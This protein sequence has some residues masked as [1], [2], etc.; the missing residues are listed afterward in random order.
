MAFNSAPTRNKIPIKEK[1]ISPQESIGPKERAVQDLVNYNTTYAP[2]VK[3][4]ERALKDHPNHHTEASGGNG[5]LPPTNSKNIGSFSEEPND[6]NINILN[7]NSTGVKQIIPSGTVNYG[8]VNQTIIINNGNNSS[9]N[10]SVGGKIVTE[11]SRN[12]NIKIGNVNQE[13]IND[14]SRRISMSDFNQNIPK[15]EVPNVNIENPRVINTESISNT[16]LKENRIDI[17]AL[18]ILSDAYQDPE[19]MKNE[20]NEAFEA[21][22]EEIQLEFID[23]LEKALSSNKFVSLDAKLMEMQSKISKIKSEKDR[24]IS[25]LDEVSEYKKNSNIDS[26]EYTR[27]TKE[28]IGEYRENLSQFDRTAKED[29]QLENDKLPLREHEEASFFTK[30]KTGFSRI[31][32]TLKSILNYPNRPFK[33]EKMLVNGKLKWDD[34]TKDKISNRVNARYFSAREKLGYKNANNPLRNSRSSERYDQYDDLDISGNRLD[35]QDQRKNESIE[36]GDV[37]D[38]K[39]AEAYNSQQKLNYS[40]KTKF[41]TSQEGEVVVNQ[42]ENVNYSEETPI[43][44]DGDFSELTTKYA[45]YTEELKELKEQKEPLQEQLDKQQED[46][47]IDG[48]ENFKKMKE[49]SNAIKLM[50]KHSE[51][52]RVKLLESIEKFNADL[53]NFSQDRIDEFEDVNSLSDVNR[54]KKAFNSGRYTIPEFSGLIE[55]MPPA[56][57]SSEI[58]PKEKEILDAVA[59]I[60]KNRT[61]VTNLFFSINKSITA[62]EN[63]YSSE[64][65]IDS[66]K[67]Y[68]NKEGEILKRGNFQVKV[69]KG[70]VKGIVDKKVNGESIESEIE[71]NLDEKGRLVFQNNDIREFW[72]NDFQNE[73]YKIAN[74]SINEQMLNNLKQ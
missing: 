57:E 4:L 25:Q 7:T 10:Q 35:Y 37:V 6:G 3:V 30:R 54:I 26:K 23:V 68:A 62:K 66:L 27:S 34:T 71:L 32:S 72:I 74:K 13:I 58:D 69:I 24:F 5:N 60:N 47:E 17:K 61:D 38:N 48:A 59:K 22:Y 45:E 67:S 36:V 11:G 64:A 49:L 1:V 33:A 43:M 46:G 8:T 44:E 55:N 14:P 12:V 21:E 39:Q 31:K 15:V 16:P 53:Y 20:T 40:N 19:S 51:I 73:Y 28:S 70:E 63:L 29:Y 50:E 65:S 42:S 41:D 18:Q 9:I 2:L 56:G 52:I